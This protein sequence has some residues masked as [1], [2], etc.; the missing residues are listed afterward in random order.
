MPMVVP[1]MTTMVVV[2]AMVSSPSLVDDYRW[3]SVVTPAVIGI[4]VY[5]FSAFCESFSRLKVRPFSAALLV[6]LSHRKPIEGG[7]EL[8]YPPPSI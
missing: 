5:F 2:M 4:R 7:G 6:A 1:M 3:A 8:G